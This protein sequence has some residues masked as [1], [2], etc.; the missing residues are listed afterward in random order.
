MGYAYRHS[1][2]ERAKKGFVSISLVIICLGI[3]F[4]FFNF[5]HLPSQIIL[6]KKSIN[7]FLVRWQD[8]L[9]EWGE[10]SSFLIHYAYLGVFCVCVPVYERGLVESFT[11]KPRLTDQ[12]ITQAYY[13]THVNAWQWIYSHEYLA[14]QV[15]RWL[16]R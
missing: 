5:H 1:H 9:L 4:F 3:F 8:E 12:Q 15:R 11:H 10:F 6:K 16:C 7:N 2:N 14:R 13:T